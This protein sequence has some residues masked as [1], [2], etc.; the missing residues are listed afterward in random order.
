LNATATV[1]ALPVIVLLEI[2]A[3]SAKRA[4]PNVG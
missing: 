1:P 3:E 2:S 4:A